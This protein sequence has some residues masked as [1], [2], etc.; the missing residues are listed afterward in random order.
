MTT[1]LSVQV[2]LCTRSPVCAK[3]HSLRMRS[4]H[5]PAERH[6]RKEVSWPVCTAGCLGTRLRHPASRG[7]SP[8]GAGDSVLL[9]SVPSVPS[10]KGT[11]PGQQRLPDPGSLK[12][13]LHPDPPRLRD[14]EASAPEQ[15]RQRAGSTEV[16]QG[17]PGPGLCRAGCRSRATAPPCHDPWGQRPVLEAHH[18]ALV[19]NWGFYPY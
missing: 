12:S 2:K 5:R 11:V 1:Q 8:A 9:Q 16:Q 17:A 10:P 6:P 13:L 18:W 3:P 19:L 7:E 14:E 15:L 4:C